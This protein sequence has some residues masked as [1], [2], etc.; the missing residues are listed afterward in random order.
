[1]KVYEIY[2]GKP[3]RFGLTVPQQIA[4]LVGIVPALWLERYWL[5]LICIPLAVILTGALTRDDENILVKFRNMRLPNFI[6]GKYRKHT[7]VSKIIR[8]N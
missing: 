8:K 5:L 6:R 7:F 4:A 3:K 1:M 2:S